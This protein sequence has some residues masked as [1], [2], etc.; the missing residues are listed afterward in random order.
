MPWVA[1]GEG[2]AVDREEEK[3]EENTESERCDRCDA[4]NCFVTDKD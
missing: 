1:F 2:G 4:E 3:P